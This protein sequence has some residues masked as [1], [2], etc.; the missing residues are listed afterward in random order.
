ME[1]FERQDFVIWRGECSDAVRAPLAVRV[2]VRSAKAQ[3][4]AIPFQDE[5]L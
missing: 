5:R 3:V 2:E 1:S 4:H